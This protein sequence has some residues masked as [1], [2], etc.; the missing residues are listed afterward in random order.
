MATLDIQ[1]SMGVD[2]V[3]ARLDRAVF[4]LLCALAVVL[5]VSTAG[6]EI[7]GAAAIFLFLINRGITGCRQGGAAGAMGAV[8]LRLVIPLV[9]FLGICGLSILWSVDPKLSLRA[10]GGKSIGA[11][12]LLVT[13]AGTLTSRDRILRFSLCLLASAFVV[14]MDGGWQLWQGHDL[15]RGEALL[16]GC[17]SA[18]MNHPNGLGAYLIFALLPALSLMLWSWTKEA[19]GVFSLISVRSLITGLTVVLCVVLGFTFSRGAWVGFL[20]GGGVLVALRRRYLV[21]LVLVV[22]LFLVIFLPLIISFRHAAL[23]SNNPLFTQSLDVVGSGRIGFWKDA[24]HIIS[25]YPLGTGL[26]TYTVVIRKYVTT[27]HA[28]PHNSYLQ[29]AAEIGMAGL[30]V[31]L[32]FIWSFVQVTARRIARSNHDAAGALAVGFLAGWAGIMVQSGLDTTFYSV[33]LS[34]MLWL[35]MGLLLA[36]AVMMAK[37]RPVTETDPDI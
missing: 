6:V 15:L 17:V 7:C 10:F 13:A 26:N 8:P 16:R 34:R 12:L 1:G 22:V 36:A 18:S 31:F 25:D 24:V 33:Q 35:V 19:Q 11:A 37:D 3:R 21:P 4:V 28:Y 27:W 20:V 14:A 30:I 2:V 9:F 32:W 29:M 23:F 5:P